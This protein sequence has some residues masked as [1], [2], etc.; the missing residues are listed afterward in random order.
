MAH[1]GLS[2]DLRANLRRG[3]LMIIGGSDVKDFKKKK[4]DNI[5]F[6]NLFF[7]PEKIERKSPKA[8]SESLDSPSQIGFCQDLSIY[9]PSTSSLLIALPLGAI[10]SFHFFQSHLNRV[11]FPKF[12]NFFNLSFD[13]CSLS[14]CFLI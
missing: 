11:K 12:L 8:R 13:L 7:C 1:E 5:F 9:K 10:A 14:S 3:E 4:D 2:C 6:L